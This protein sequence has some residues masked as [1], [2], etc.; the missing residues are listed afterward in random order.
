MLKVDV[1]GELSE[2]NNDPAVADQPED[3]EI[4]EQKNIEPIEEHYFMNKAF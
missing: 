2:I 3:K 1:N 4:Q